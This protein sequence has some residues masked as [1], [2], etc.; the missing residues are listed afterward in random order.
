MFQAH[1]L[2]RTARLFFITLL[3]SIWF[4]ALNP[5]N[6]QIPP[7][8]L[9]IT[10]VNPTN[11]PEVVITANVFD[12]FNQPV[13][14][15]T[16]AD[17]TLSG[18][19]AQYGEIVSVENIADDALAFS[20]V[21]VVDVS[22]SMYGTPIEKLR[23]AVTEYVSLLDAQNEVAIMTFGSN[24]ELIQPFT[25]DKA[26][27]EAVIATLLEGGETALYQGSYDSLIYASESG[28]SRRAIIL[29]SDGAEYGGRS[30]VIP[31]DVF[32]LLAQR[33]VT[34]YT[35]GLGFG[36][37]RSYLEA[38]AT[39]S[40]GAFY[41]SPTPEQ[42]AEIY[43]GLAARLQSQ[44]VITLNVPTGEDGIALDGT[45]YEAIFEVRH[46][47]NSAN[48][49][50][51]VRAPIPVPMFQVD[52]ATLPDPITE[53]LDLTID[54][55]ADDPLTQVDVLWDGVAL[56]GFGDLPYHLPIDPVNFTP[57]AH[58]LSLTAVDEDG[59]SNGVTEV[60]LN[61]GALPSA[62]RFNPDVSSLGELTTPTAVTVEVT[63]Q[64]PAISVQYTLDEGD[65]IT[66]AESPYSILLN[67][68]DFAVGQ[69]TLSVEVTN[70]GGE[71]STAETTFTIGSVSPQITFVGL[72]DGQAL[73][74]EPLDFSI[75]V[76]SQTQAP[77]ITVTVNGDVLEATNPEGTQYTLDPYA[78]IPGTAQL[79]VSVTD[80]NGASNNT[81]V[82]LSVPNL[83]PIPSVNGLSDG[84][85]LT[86]T[87][88]V[89]LS[90]IS[91]SPVENVTW[92][93]DGV[94]LAQ[95]ST[96]PFAL[97]L[98]PLDVGSGVHTLR[99]TAEN[100]SGGSS[101]IDIPFSVD[102]GVLQ[103]ATA[104]AP[105]ATATVTPTLAATLT[106]TLT[107]TLSEVV[108]EEPSSLAI[109]T[110]ST[111][112]ALTT[113]AEARQGTA[114][115]VAQIT[116]TAQQLSLSLATQ[117]A[118]GTQASLQTATQGAQLTATAE[119]NATQSAVE[120]QSALA[121]N[122]AITAT[123]DARL[124]VTA[125]SNATQSAVETQS[126]LATSDAITA[127]AEASLPE[128]MTATA[129]A[130]ATVQ[131]QVNATATTLAQDILNATQQVRETQ[132][133][134]A[135]VTATVLAQTTLTAE[136]AF[137][138]QT[139][140]AA[141]LNAQATQTQNALESALETQ[142]AATQSA[143]LTATSV[144]ASNATATEAQ[145]LNIQQT[146][147]QLVNEATE[148]AEAQAVFLTATSLVMD[149][150]ASAIAQTEEAT[151]TSDPMLLTA[152]QLI[153]EATQTGAALADSLTQS[154]ETPTFAPTLTPL[155]TD[156][157][158]PSDTIFTPIVLG[159][160]AILLV[161]LVVYILM[162]RQRP[163][164]D[165]RHARRRR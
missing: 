165:R 86:A 148:T 19:L 96:A 48:A 78:I 126:A 60:V 72:Q 63:G 105:T 46:D 157:S 23:E 106:S 158:A 136:A 107:A 53:P 101:F 119:S 57:G 10:G 153:I 84:D 42:L 64:T 54:V 49:T 89:E 99:I 151:P 25:N 35:I 47:E 159:C 52:P 37:D 109:D 13:A 118:G 102:E 16:Q 77:D 5:S 32:D 129:D 156:T 104:N 124:T 71:T 140:Q 67:P 40:N 103:T 155:T 9:E 152:T 55:L 17:F 34:I 29:L 44:Y 143:E 81:T 127:T 41:E 160:V 8:T 58:T 128:N 50:A 87:R 66:L 164:E 97:S 26:E 82:N 39:R 38:L 111:E 94:D 20:T 115:G 75:D 131:S 12:Q 73:P 14:G 27:L 113:T 116:S 21:L 33:G 123:Q 163:K 95:Q 146:A 133:A 150:T 144:S 93:L 22:S 69:H 130:R 68:L 36:S 162:S 79:G 18:E 4:L 15:L 88:S 98:D 132:T 125:E 1:F 24:V 145:A 137:Q 120:T 74:S 142:T 149:A 61:I 43:R 3:A 2:L 90:F 70:E 114:T 122:D 62:I 11:M 45:E 108:T 112:V 91:Q 100:A 31:Q 147:T 121:T 80:A 30:S 141:T 56:T 110:E 92:V 76:H 134:V 65:P 6:A 7:L 154:A 83:P 161:L 51:T 59:D 117:Q 28:L 138:Q 139:Q 85:V 135:N